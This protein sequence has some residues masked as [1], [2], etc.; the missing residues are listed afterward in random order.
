MA[1]PAIILVLLRGMWTGFTAARPWLV[2]LVVAAI[3][4]LYLPAG[5]HV[6]L[7]AI[8]GIASAFFLI[9]ENE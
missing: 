2:S 4:Y 1:F 5:W 3:A 7:G 6:P 8:S 9:G